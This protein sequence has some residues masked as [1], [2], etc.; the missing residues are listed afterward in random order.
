[1]T[2]PIPDWSSVALAGHDCRVCVP[3]EPLPGRAVV[4]LHDLRG[5]LAADVTPL[6]AACVAAGLTVIAPRTGRSWWLDRP[7]AGCP[8]GLTPERLVVDH[9]VPEIGR[10]FD[11]RPPGLAVMGIGMGG[12]GALRLAYR[13]PA[14]FP[15]TAAIA[16]AIDFHRGMREAGEHDDGDLFDTLWETFGD[17]ERARQ[18][19]AILHVHPLNWPRHHF[20]ASDPADARWHDGADRL[21]GKLVALGIPHTAMLEPT[22]DFLATATAAAVRFV[23]AALEQESRRLPGG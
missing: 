4:L 19:T 20:F 7:M 12:Q 1:M 3:P 14:V 13:H 10:R 17:I 11:V 6:G 5:E 23:C 21:H 18:D 8:A 2:A 9:V 22:P 16:P 15:V